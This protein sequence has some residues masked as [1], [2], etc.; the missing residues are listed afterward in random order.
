[1]TLPAAPPYPL[2]ATRLCF[3]FCFSALYLVDRDGVSPFDVRAA[4]P[5]GAG[6]SSRQPPL[7][8]SSTGARHEGLCTQQGERTA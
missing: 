1:M 8:L 2:T 5:G 6:S 3:R 4:G 7:R